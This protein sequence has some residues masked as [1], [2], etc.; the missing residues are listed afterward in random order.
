[1]GEF[2]PSDPFGEYSEGD[3]YSGGYEPT[4]SAQWSV[5]PPA[6]TW[7]G[8]EADNYGGE[9][10]GYRDRGDRRDRDRGEGL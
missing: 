5:P 6:G 7:E 4:A 9:R 2:P 8:G 10:G 3:I 1:M